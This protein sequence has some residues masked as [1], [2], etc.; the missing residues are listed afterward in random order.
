MFVSRLISNDHS[1]F[2][3]LLKCYMFHILII[4][5]IIAILTVYSYNVHGLRPDVLPV[6]FYVCDIFCI[7]ETSS[8]LQDIKLV[9]IECDCCNTIELYRN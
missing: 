9:D 3:I 7:Q 2:F 5:I 6:L 4:I 1:L 8:A